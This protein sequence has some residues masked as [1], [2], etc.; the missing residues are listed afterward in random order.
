MFLTDGV[1]SHKASDIRIA[2]E[3]A[4]PEGGGGGGVP[5]IRGAGRAEQDSKPSQVTQG[6]GR[7]ISPACIRPALRLRSDWWSHVT[8]IQPESE[9]QY[10]AYIHQICWQIMQKIVTVA[11]RNP[12]V[13][14]EE[15]S[16]MGL[17]GKVSGGVWGF[18]T[19]TD[20]T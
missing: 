13:G 9:S 4:S 19:Q 8:N 7:S 11:S 10:T 5:R 18:C 3:S 16:S 14:S 12:P 6:S 20:N 1:Y 17:K 2:T 15:V